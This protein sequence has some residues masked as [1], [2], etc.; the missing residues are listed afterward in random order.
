MP[1]PCLSISL[2]TAILHSPAI[3]LSCCPKVQTVRRE[4][5]KDG[6]FEL[7]SL[8]VPVPRQFACVCHSVTMKCGVKENHVALHNWGKSHSQIFKLKTTEKWMF[9]LIFRLGHTVLVIELTARLCILI[10][11]FVSCYTACKWSTTVK[12]N[13]EILSSNAICFG[14]TNHNQT[15]YQRN[16]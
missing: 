7:L 2:F 14:S 16:F 5:F 6:W 3:Q 11:P 1:V 12:H 4:G 15:L 13:T 8:Q 9:C 10:H